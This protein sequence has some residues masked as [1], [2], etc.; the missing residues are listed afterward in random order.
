MPV[1]IE[2]LTGEVRIHACTKLT[3][4]ASGLSDVYWV[5]IKTQRGEEVTFFMPSLDAA[6]AY[7]N[8]INTVNDRDHNEWAMKEL[9]RQE[10]DL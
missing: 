1:N 5:S 3:A 4:K 8:A 10:G 6:E 7:A 2:M 9:K